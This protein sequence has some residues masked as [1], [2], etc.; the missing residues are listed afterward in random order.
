MEAQL[1]FAYEE[2]AGYIFNY[3]TFAFAKTLKLF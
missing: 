2:S 3:L 1:G